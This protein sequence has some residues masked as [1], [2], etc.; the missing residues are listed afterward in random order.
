MSAA[1]AFVARSS[2]RARVVYRVRAAH[3]DVLARRE[4]VLAE[5]L[6]MLLI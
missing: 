5:V 2:H 4:L 1:P 6:K 3:R